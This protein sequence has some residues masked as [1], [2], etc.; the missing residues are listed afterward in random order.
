MN[1]SIPSKHFIAVRREV[2]ENFQGL[3]VNLLVY[4]P[5]T[6]SMWVSTFQGRALRMFYPRE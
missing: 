4:K 5:M 3:L 1:L 6:R 2:E